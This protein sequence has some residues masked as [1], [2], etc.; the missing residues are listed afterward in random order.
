MAYKALITKL[1]NVRKDPNSDRLYLAECFGEGIIVG[2]DMT[3]GMLVMYLPADGQIFRWFGDRLR[4]FR[5]NEDGT[6]QGGYLE[7]NGHIKAIK[8]RGNRSEGIAISLDRIKET[9]G[10]QLLKEG[11]E[12]TELNGKEFCRKFIPKQRSFKSGQKKTSYKGKKALQVVYPEFDLHKDTE[13]LRYNLD[14]FR[15]G[16]IL[17][18]SAKLHGTSQRSMKTYGMHKRGFFRRLFHLK[19]KTTK[20]YVL[21]TRRTIV[22]DEEGGYYGNDAFRIKHHKRIE[23]FVTDGMEVFYEVVGWYGDEPRATIM[24]IGDNR[25]IKDKNFVK[26]FGDET[27][28]SYGCKPGES[29]MFVYRITENGRDY[30]TEEIIA[31]CEKA[32]VKHVPYIMRIKFTTPEDLTRRIDEY[33]EDLHDP[34][35]PSHIKEGV[36]VRRIGMRRW[37]AYKAKTFE[38]KVLENII[39]DTGN[40][41]MEEAQ[42]LAEREETTNVEV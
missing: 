17:E 38:F 12:I 14:K 29:E 11:D 33:F 25:K 16:E 19:P 1:Q 41:D 34:I 13:Q 28:F 36:V 8:L 27:I 30:S 4:L 5:K 21:G 18:I 42:E 7:D 6:A 40:L 2:E 20:E 15:E 39:K 35:D 10:E 37:E 22:Q 31:W 3:E 24:P 23:P 9:F 32:G 26:E